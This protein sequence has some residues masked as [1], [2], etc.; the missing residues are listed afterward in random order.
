MSRGAGTSGA[1][2]VLDLVAWVPF[3]MACAFVSL[4]RSFHQAQSQVP[5]R[6]YPPIPHIGVVSAFDPLRTS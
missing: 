2:E 6:R 3:G 1:T 5:K 4:W